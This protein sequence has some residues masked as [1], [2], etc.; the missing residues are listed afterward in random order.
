MGPV[1]AV[2]IDPG[3]SLFYAVVLETSAGRPSVVD[4]TVLLPS[5]LRRLRDLCR[6][7]ASVAIDAPSALSEGLHAAEGDL[8]GKFRTA[9]CGEIA[10]RAD[11]SFSVQF[12]TPT[13][14]RDAKPWMVEGFRLWNA[15]TEHGHAP[16]E[17]YPHAAFCR[18]I[19]S[20]PNNKKTREGASARLEMLARQLHLPD[21]AGGWCHDTIDAAVAALVAMWQAT[22]GPVVAAAPR[23]RR[24]RRLRDLD[25]GVTA[26]RAPGRVNLLGDHTDYCDGFVLPMAIDRECRVDVARRE[27]GRVRARSRELLGEVDVAADAGEPVDRVEPAWGRFVGGVVHE[28]V[29]RGAEIPGLDLTVTSSVPPGSG[30]SSSS[31][32]SVGLTLAIAD[33]AGCALDPVEVAQAA[34]GAEVRAT[35]VPGGLM[36]QLA[37][38]FGRA[39]HALL[40][41]C[42]RLSAEPVRL[43]DGIDVVVVHSGLPRTLA[44]SAYAE[45]RAECEAAADRLGVPALRDATVEQVG[46]DARARHVVTEN[47]R[48]LAAADA[49]RA[50][51]LTSLG[52]L[53]LASHAS[54]RD[55][56]E[57]S[58]PELDVLVELL[59]EHGA[60]GARL[61]GAGF[62]GCVVALVADDR[63]ASLLAELPSRYRAATGLDPQAFV[64]QAVDGAGAAPT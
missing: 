29:A 20:T 30:L 6:D 4:S 31:A 55:D 13:E 18:L 59:V 21:D 12:T 64:V 36:D 28:L 1:R 22:D 25:A 42:R 63:T 50:G 40:I 38:I 15:L 43:P 48:V 41:D 14:L 2:G 49:L 35:G 37:A 46:G 17:V 19:G 32:L 54:L 45:R 60:L 44:G 33:A 26:W 16:I 24:P 3:A 52:P 51:D 39:G 9:R 61:T 34:L 27:E 11:H 53:L 5:E 47:A 8:P 62:G 58:T 10:L 56:F 23:A 7:A 57:V